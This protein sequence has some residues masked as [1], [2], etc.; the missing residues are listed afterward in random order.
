MAPNGW[1]GLWPGHSWTTTN[2]EVGREVMGLQMEASAGQ[3]KQGGWGVL[4]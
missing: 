1:P 2:S 3:E 4:G